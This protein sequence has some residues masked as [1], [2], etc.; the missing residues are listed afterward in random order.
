MKKFLN[1]NALYKIAPLSAIAMCSVSS[2]Y[3]SEIF[4]G[5]Q[6]LGSTIGKGLVGLISIVAFV[7]IV[8]HAI[9]LV[10]ESKDEKKV[11]ARKESIKTVL[12]GYAIA[13]L[14]SFILTT[15]ASVLGEAFGTGSIIT[16]SSVNTNGGLK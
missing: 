15:L 6:N 12:K 2:V 7:L 13:L 16:T 8:W 4:S 5:L 14:A 1:R 11:A 3:C 10:I 9:W